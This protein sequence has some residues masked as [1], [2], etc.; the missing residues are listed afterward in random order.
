MFDTRQLQ[1]QTVLDQ[2]A[3]FIR[4]RHSDSQSQPLIA[5]SHDYQ[6]YRSSQSLEGINLDALY[7]ELLSCW[8]FI[9]RQQSAQV[10]APQWEQLLGNSALAYRNAFPSAYRDHFSTATAQ[11]DIALLEQLLGFDRSSSGTVALQTLHQP[12]LAGVVRRGTDS[13]EPRDAGDR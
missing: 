5:F 6:I 3:E 13:R 10:E 8:R 2:L 7:T 11:Q 9:E 12:G 1:Q 4:Q